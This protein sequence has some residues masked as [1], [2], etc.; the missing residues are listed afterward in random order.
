MILLEAKK[1]LRADMY[2]NRVASLL[3]AVMAVFMLALGV[4]TVHAESASTAHVL[5]E[6]VKND[7]IAVIKKKE[8]L[9]QEG[10]PEKYYAEIEAVLVP[11]VD[12]GYIS[13]GVMGKYVKSASDSQKAS[14]AKTFQQGLVTT[15]GKGLAG[16]ADHDIQVLPPEGDVTGKRSLSVVLRVQGGDT[17]NILSFSMKQNRDKE[18]KITNMILN[19]INLGKTFR[20]QFDQAM[21]KS[22][23]L[24]QVIA[25][26]RV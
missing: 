10:G 22:G 20:N 5:A 14:F 9:E 18:W 3:S 8:S 24:D 26:W 1:S 12:F 11:V 16:Y 19:G 13:R 25:D 6:D 2:V 4:A 7:L 21:Q 17:T 23:N 15:Y